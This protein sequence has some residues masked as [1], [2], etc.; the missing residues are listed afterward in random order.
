[1]GSAEGNDY[2]FCFAGDFGTVPFAGQQWDAA[3]FGKCHICT[4]YVLRTERLAFGGRL[5]R[6]CGEKLFPLGMGPPEI[7]RPLQTWKRPRQSRRREDTA[8]TFVS[9]EIGTD[10]M[11]GLPFV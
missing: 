7:K 9:V 2:S 10:G 4:R 8:G 6:A 3:V 1:M 11:A 5:G